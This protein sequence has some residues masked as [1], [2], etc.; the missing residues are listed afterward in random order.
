MPD[1]NPLITD[2]FFSSNTVRR[3]PSSESRANTEQPQ[4]VNRN[5]QNSNTNRVVRISDS[6]LSNAAESLTTAPDDQR[7]FGNQ[8]PINQYQLNQQLLRREE[9]D[10]LVGV[11][12]FA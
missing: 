4:Q 5:P 7:S 2:R 9:L 11:D 6:T 1:L 3:N 8:P 12:L 10:G